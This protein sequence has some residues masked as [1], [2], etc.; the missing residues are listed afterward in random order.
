MK[1]PGKCCLGLMTFALLLSIAFA[2]PPPYQPPALSDAKNWTMVLIPDPQTYVKLS[3][4]QGIFDLM[5]AWIADN[6]KALNIKQVLITGD[7]VGYNGIKELRPEV[8]DVTG[9]QQWQ[10]ISRIMTRLDGKVPYIFCTGNHD[11]GIQSAENRET[12]VNR[13]FTPGRNPA[14]QPFF[15]EC[16][17]NSFGE[18]TLENAA[19]RFPLP[20]GRHLLVISLAFAPTA[21]EAAWAKELAARAEYKDDFGILLTHAY[22]DKKG[23]R[24][25]KDKYQLNLDGGFT[26]EEIWQKLVRLSPNIRMV[27]CGH[28]A[29]PDVWEGGISYAKDVNDAGKEVYQMAFNTQAI[30]G[31]WHGNGGDGWLR[32]LEFTPDL[33][34]IKV[35]TFSPLFAISPS[36]RHLAWRTEP[37]NQFDIQ[38][39]E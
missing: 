4:N 32:L 30:G 21:G 28:I 25:A 15:I 14:N 1:L 9:E 26:G 19:W 39:A 37:L 16:G 22:L 18:K 3:R 11:Y 7:L 23:K 31:G 38:I 17:P 5:T 29:V 34:T 10:A 8:N 2:A 6:Q 27:I 13:Y 35:R 36:T 12:G 20:G 24:I 33:T